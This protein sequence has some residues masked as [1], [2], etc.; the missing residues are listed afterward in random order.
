M[1]I[2]PAAQV[3]LVAVAL[4]V[5]QVLAG[6]ASAERRGIPLVQVVEV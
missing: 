2:I 5:I 4:R 1:L 6:L 3:G